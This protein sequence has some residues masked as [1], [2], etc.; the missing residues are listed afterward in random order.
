MD[1]YIRDDELMHVGVSILDGAPGRG[2]G[3]YEYGSGDNPFQHV[4]DFLGR[5]A[6]L[7]HE[8]YSE[9]QIAEAMG[10]KNTTQL[11][12]ELEIAR[13]EKDEIEYKKILEL[14]A[15]GYS[16][17]QIAEIMGF[18]GESTVRSKL[19][20]GEKGRS[21]IARNTVD[22]LKERLEEDG[23]ID[24]TAGTELSVLD[25]I[26]RTKL[27][28][29]LY[30]LEKEGYVVH[31]IYVPQAV[32]KEQGTTQL[33]LTKGDVTTA[34][35]KDNLD[36][37]AIL[38]NYITTDNGASFRPAFVYPASLD[39]K[40]LQVVYAE[41]GGL[42]KDGVIELRRGVEDIS[43]GGSHYAQVRILVDGTHYLKGMA[44]Y[45]DDLPEGI[46]VRFNTNKHKGT[47]I[48]GED[49]KN[50][51]LKLIEPDPENPFGSLI[52]ENGGQRYYDDPNGKYIDPLT[53][54]R[55]SLS[56]INKRAEEGDWQEW[57]KKLPSQF[58]AKQ[59]MTLISRQL[60]LDI[61]DTEAEFDEIK[62]YTNPTVKKKLLMEFANGCDA[63]AVDLQAAAL[64]RARYQVILPIKNIK[65]TEIFAPNFD[66]GEKV[67]LVRFPHAGPSEIPILTVNNKNKEA[68][69]SITK[70]ATDAVGINSKVAARLSGADF[71]GDTVMVIPT[72]GNGK[73]GKVNILSKYPL[74]EGFDPKESYPAVEG[75]RYMK[76]TD[77]VTGKKKDNTQNEMGKISNLITDMSLRGASDDEMARALRHSMVVIDAGKHKLNY[78]K[79][80]IDNDISEL[81]KK[82]QVHIDENGKLKYGGASTLLSRAGGEARTPKTI[83]SPQINPKTGELEY[84]TD[85]YK[86]QQTTQ[87][88]KVKNAYELSSG[89][90]KESLYAEYANKMKALANDAR[91]E[92]LK[93]KDIPYDPSAKVKYQKEVAEI[94]GKLI[95]AKANAPRERAAQRI[96]NVEIKSK[97]AAYPDL[98]DSEV[99]KI[100]QQAITRARAQTGASRK[101]TAIHLTDREWEA[102]QNGAITK[103]RLSEV[104]RYMP[105]NEVKSFAMPKATTTLSPAKVT[106]LKAMRQSGYT[107]SQIA[108]ALGVSSATVSRIAKQEG[109]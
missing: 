3:R 93:T 42:D 17:P 22:F 75:M 18:K 4:R 48:L 104:L 59:D 99:K 37:V 95:T 82:Y 67:A 28:E 88:A 74:V 71:D 92:I 91:L 81:K 72:S 23:M 107:N 51:V 12:R 33:V 78:K 102:I 5:V 109:V 50:S 62:N 45:S 21:T 69:Y 32:N 96:A 27:N 9:Q 87:M 52:K 31:K 25:G 8:G 20:K 79:S 19:A 57:K 103:T 53:G 54:K 13:H 101:D 15:K 35:V 24:V 90:A 64:P 73:N 98:T 63:A 49:S 94:G 55:Q 38:D 44:L 26:S 16:G 7:K 84:K 77:P 1:N 10:F 80:E 106:K 30:L 108:E 61:A 65:D 83:G 76:Y 6:Q 34:E 29:A 66:E 58:L 41:D 68:L 86:K 43:L 105:S 39:S 14:Q 60:K 85:P 2:S 70:Q 36:K 100:S 89:T 46:D 40:R 47:P 11:R 56:L 97:K